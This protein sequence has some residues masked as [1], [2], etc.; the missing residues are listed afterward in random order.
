M[1]CKRLL[2]TIAAAL[3]LAFVQPVLADSNTPTL[4]HAQV[5][6][7][8]MHMQ[9]WFHDSF[10]DLREDLAE[11]EAAGKRLVIIWEQRGCPYCK[12]MH[13][14]NLRIPRIAD[15]IQRDF[16]VIQM[17][18]WGHREV[19]DFDGEVLKEKDLA[20]KWAVLFTPTLQFFPQAVSSAAGKSGKAAEVVRIPGYFK[21][22][23]FYFLFRYAKTKGYESE[24]NFQRWLGG[25]GN[26]LEEAGVKYDLY[27]D[28]LPANLPDDL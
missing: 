4:P 5:G 3:V 19:T 26:K 23:H 2:S 15:T 6:E 1:T 13:E 16:M 21:P 7:D 8:G 10:L 18:L 24:P 17:N 11:A 22:F 14:V 12:R 27:A 28:E 9:S 25:I 20:E